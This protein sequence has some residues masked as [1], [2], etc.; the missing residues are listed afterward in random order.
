MEEKVMEDMKEYFKTMESD[1]ITNPKVKVFLTRVMNAG[2]QLYKD[3]INSVQNK[4]DINA[5][6]EALQQSNYVQV[7]YKHLPQVGRSYKTLADEIKA[8]TSL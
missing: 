7:Q 4:N 8:D 5:V 2:S 6:S 1:G 3:I